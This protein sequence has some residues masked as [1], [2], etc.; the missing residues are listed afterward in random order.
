MSFLTLFTRSL[1]VLLGLLP[2]LAATPPVT[3]E[4]DHA[5][6]PAVSA[7]A[8]AGDAD[9]IRE[10]VARGAWLEARDDSGRTPLL[11]ATHAND[12]PVATVLIEAGADVNA[13]DDMQDSP[14]L[15]A[16]ASG[17]NEILRL[18][19]DH[20]ADLKSTNRFGG[21]ALI[22]ACERGHVETVRILIKAGV[23]VDHVNRLGWTGLLEAIILS[24]GGP[25]QQKIVRQ[26]IDAGAYV[27]LADFEGVTP[28]QHAEG[29]GFTIIAGMLREA[30]AH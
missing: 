5:L 16:G 3:R 24:D 4:S 23:D 7:A 17:F 2:A 28:L 30:G 13:M 15:Y 9:A 27:N 22:P 25:A 21:T 1:A 6:G 29:R 26:L 14:F 18:T 11:I 12:I 10:L 20:E 8:I 19:L